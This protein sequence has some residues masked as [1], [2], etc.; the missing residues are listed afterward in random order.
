MGRVL[1]TAA[2]AVGIAVAAAPAAPAAPSAV[3]L[4]EAI[5]TVT[6]ATD[7]R[8]GARDDRGA[9]LDGLKVIRARGRYVGVYH[10]P[11]GS[12]FDV[13]VATSPDLM[14]WTRRATLDVDASQATLARAGRGFVV[15]YEK[16]FT[17]D[18]LPLTR[19]PQELDVANGLLGR[20]RIRFRHYPTLDRLLGG[21]HGRQFTAPRTAALTAEGTP[22]IESV[23]TNRGIGRSRIEVGLH[24]FADTDGDLFPDADRQGTGTLTNFRQWNDGDDPAVNDAFLGLRTLHPGFESAPVGNIG[25]REAVGSSDGRMALHEAQYRPGEWGTWRLFLR[26]VASQVVSPVD[27]QTHGG[28][29]AF[30]NPSLTRLRLPDGTHALF[31]SMFVFS[32]G[33]AAG[34]AGSL[35]FYRVEP[36][37]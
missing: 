34:E 13:H 10:A 7:H 8:Y 22:H 31:A 14:T 15:A 24:H 37:G 21:D 35:I 20:I 36:G 19:L 9:T 26:H 12:S 25:D 4:S 27:V 1:L 29:T 2:L 6:E 5:S 30:G 23:T 16:A 3:W 11:G 17:A 28:S 33:A 32:E 18:V